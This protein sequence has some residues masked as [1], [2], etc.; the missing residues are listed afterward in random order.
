[1]KIDNK[2]K[3]LTKQKFVSLLNKSLLLR[4]ILFHYQIY[5]ILNSICSLHSNKFWNLMLL[6]MRQI[7]A[8]QFV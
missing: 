3:Y 6:Y 1:M 4:E 5:A 8:K 2:T 7:E